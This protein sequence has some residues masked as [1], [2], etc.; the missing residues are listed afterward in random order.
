MIQADPEVCSEYI[1]SA[2]MNC[3]DHFTQELVPEAARN[4]AVSNAEGFAD[5]LSPFICDFVN[6]FINNVN[7]MWTDIIEATNTIVSA[8]KKALS[9]PKKLPQAISKIMALARKLMDRVKSIIEFLVRI[10]DKIYD[11]ALKQIVKAYE[12]LDRIVEDIQQ[13]LESLC[14]ERRDNLIIKLTQKRNATNNEDKIAYYNNKIAEIEAME[15]S[16]LV[17]LIVGPPITWPEIPDFV[18][19]LGTL[20]S[21]LINSAVSGFNLP[22]LNTQMKFWQSQAPKVDTGVID[23]KIAAIT[24]YTNAKIDAI[25]K[26]V[27]PFVKAFNDIIK[28]IKILVS[29]SIKA[30]LKWLLKLPKK[31]I[32]AYLGTA[33]FCIKFIKSI[34]VDKNPLGAIEDWANEKFAGLAQG[35]KDAAEA[36]QGASDKLN[37]FVDNF[38]KEIMDLVKKAQDGVQELVEYI[39]EKTA[40][41]GSI[42]GSVIEAATTVY[43]AIVGGITYVISV[44][45]ANL[46]P[47]LALIGMGVGLFSKPV[48]TSPDPDEPSVREP[49]DAAE[50]EFDEMYYQLVGDEY[51]ELAIDEDG[52]PM[53]LNND[54]SVVEIDEDGIRPVDPF[55]PIV[56]Y[57][58]FY[59][60]NGEIAV[61]SNGQSIR[62]NLSDYPNNAIAAPLA[63]PAILEK[64]NEPD[65]TLW[66]RLRNDN[67]AS[68]TI[69]IRNPGSTGQVYTFTDC[70]WNLREIEEFKF[71]GINYIGPQPIEEENQIDMDDYLV[72]GSGVSDFT[73]DLDAPGDIPPETE[74]YEGTFEYVRKTIYD[75]S[76]TAGL[77]NLFVSYADRDP[78]SNETRIMESATG[79]F[80][81]SKFSNEM[82]FRVRTHDKYSGP[83]R[84]AEYTADY[85]RLPSDDS[86]ELSVFYYHADDDFYDNYGRLYFED[87]VYRFGM[88]DD[89]YDLVFIP[90]VEGY[91]WDAFSSRYTFDS[92]GSG[93]EYDF[94]FP[95]GHEFT[96]YDD[97][98]SYD[99]LVSGS[100]YTSVAFVPGTVSFTTGTMFLQRPEDDDFI[101]YPMSNPADDGAVW[102]VSFSGLTDAG[103]YSYYYGFYNGTSS[104]FV[105]KPSEAFE[106]IIT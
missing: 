41:Y 68:G 93:E 86:E 79:N 52:S 65:I 47:V 28:L 102:G 74:L 32:D 69:R 16:D 91:P 8:I 23:R 18:L 55:R 15:C 75:E 43:G 4:V 25:S 97:L 9:N 94:T 7:G 11:F 96:E 5:G 66:K 48:A 103:T 106:L 21:N 60:V 87:G 83:W 31:I 2:G 76:V 56:A 17:G 14:E 3:Y 24:E 35:I 58:Y 39:A 19:G 78:I 64:L 51:V 45:V 27:E 67:E 61:D 82:R 73:D 77:L 33:K 49:V 26:F 38:V 84:G 57:G 30:V 89:S 71:Y 62:V 99:L 98:V 70:Y 34:V 6:G 36:I 81:F 12:E 13:Q 40:Y 54:G 85:N 59:A 1:V 101:E 72:G 44:I 63:D 50:Q 88:F 22:S 80:T 95:G 42:F 20:I 100:N 29:G 92:T 37:E 53:P 105:G 46:G 104:G 90:E 10:R